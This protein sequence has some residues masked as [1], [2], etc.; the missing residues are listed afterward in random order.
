MRRLIGEKPRV[1]VHPLTG[2]EDRPVGERAQI[3]QE[4][5]R[6]GEMA[7]DRRGD[8]DVV[9]PA[10]RAAPP[11]GSIDCAPEMHGRAQHVVEKTD[12]QPIVPIEIGTGGAAHPQGCWREP[13]SSR[14]CRRHRAGSRRDTARAISWSTSSCMARSRPLASLIRRHSAP[15]AALRNTRGGE[16]RGVGCVGP[17]AGDAGLHFVGAQKRP[18]GK[19]ARGRA[20][21]GARC[22]RRVEDPWRAR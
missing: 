20:R 3:G 17:A 13:E 15:H 6:I 14:C 11:I 7:R 22:D 16:T 1:A 8:H 2:K 10:K 12:R 9:P 21:L 5:E 19:H 4:L 18:I